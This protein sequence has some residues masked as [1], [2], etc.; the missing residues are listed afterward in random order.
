M[1]M[2]PNM[3]APGQQQQQQQ[4]QFVLPPGQLV[5]GSCRC[6]YPEQSGACVV[7]HPR[8]TCKICNANIVFMDL[9]MGTGLQVFDYCSPECRNKDLPRL[10]KE[11]GI[12]QESS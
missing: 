5:C 11:A 6:L 4:Q 8:A 7:C 10:D 2:F 3:C 1:N 9:S 12:L